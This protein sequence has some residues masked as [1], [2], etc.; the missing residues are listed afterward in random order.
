MSSV[1]SYC[2]S[3]YVLHS[4]GMPYSGT[5]YRILFVRD[6]FYKLVVLRIKLNKQ[7]PFSEFAQKVF[8]S[9]EELRVFNLQF[10]SDLTK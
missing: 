1:F 3:S 10:K 9:D 4:S 6:I 5:S 7:S 2:N 8:S